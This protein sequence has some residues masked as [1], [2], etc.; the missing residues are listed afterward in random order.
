MMNENKL[1]LVAQILLKEKIVEFNDLL[2]Q[3]NASEISIFLKH[4]KKI[5]EAVIDVDYYIETQEKLTKTIIFLAFAI[6]NKLIMTVD[7]SGEEYSGQV[8]RGITQILKQR[9]I[10]PIKWKNKN[11][12]KE[13]LA[14]KPKRGEFLPIL[15]KKLDN[16]LENENLAIV[17]FDCGGDEFNFFVLNKTDFEQI[18]NIKGDDFVILDTNIYDIYITEVGENTSK[19]MMYLKNKFNIPLSE[20]KS[21]IEQDK[22]LIATGNLAIMDF[23]KNEVESLGAKTEIKKRNE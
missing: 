14:S 21:F 19:V 11:L 2:S 17:F 15:F 20:I 13:I 3:Q 18:V 7:W 5:L 8:K 6:K 10:N 16:E 12:E 1:K 23:A 9:N 22:I 4:N